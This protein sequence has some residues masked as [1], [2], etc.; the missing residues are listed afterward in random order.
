MDTLN[1]K[2][3]DRRFYSPGLN[4]AELQLRKSY[5][6]T[7]LGISCFVGIMTILAYI[8]EVYSLVLFGY[9]DFL[10]VAAGKVPVNI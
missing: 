7:T 8:L 10:F 9:K 3:L 4:D 1:H 2:F 6:Y 5:W